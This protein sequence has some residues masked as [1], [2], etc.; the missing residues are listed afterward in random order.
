MRIGPGLELPYTCICVCSSTRCLLWTALR[1]MWPAT[2]GPTS[3]IESIALT[4]SG[5]HSY[6]NQAE[7]RISSCLAHL[8]PHLIQ[9]DHNWYQW[10]QG[11]VNKQKAWSS[12]WNLAVQKK[13][14]RPD[15]IPT[16][17]FMKQCNNAFTKPLISEHNISAPS[18]SPNIVGQFTYEA[19]RQQMVLRV[20]TI[21]WDLA[22]KHQ[23]DGLSC[24]SGISTCRNNIA[25]QRRQQRT[26]VMH[27]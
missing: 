2:R 12:F 21:S 6:E 26:I 20:I 22:F 11:A 13:K 7:T 15:Q 18:P 5:V 27:A 9:T 1:S 17:A 19:N 3:M 4:S 25:E 10:S 23:P 14:G 16:Q 24:H 8:I